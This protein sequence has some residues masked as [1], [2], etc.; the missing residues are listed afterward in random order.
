MK[1]TLQKCAVTVRN[2]PK[3]AP[4]FMKRRKYPRFQTKSTIHIMHG[5]FGS[6]T[7]IGIGGL[8]YIYCSWKNKAQQIIPERGTIFGPGKHYLNDIPLIVMSDDIVLNSSS[9]SPEIRKRRIRFSGLT[10]SELIKL[11]LFLLTNVNIPKLNRRR[12]TAGK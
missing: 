8:S 6:V 2:S 5:N 1:Q 12:K 4:F 9:I 10:E 11:E 3:K 7:D